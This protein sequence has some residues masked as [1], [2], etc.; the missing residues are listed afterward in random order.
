MIN[1]FAQIDYL[2]SA[3][4]SVWHRSS[5]FAKLLLT[6]WY[7]ALAVATPSWGV[8]VLLLATALGTMPVGAVCRAGSCWPPRPRR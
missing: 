8:L 5:A 7:V 1:T 6:G 3:G 4:R 2:A